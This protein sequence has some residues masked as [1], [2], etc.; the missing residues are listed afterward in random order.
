MSDCFEGIFSGGV[1]RPLDTLS[2][3]ELVVYFKVRIAVPL[4]PLDVV[5][6]SC[7]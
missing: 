7:F 2:P 1:G 4:L 6:D 3:A 5:A